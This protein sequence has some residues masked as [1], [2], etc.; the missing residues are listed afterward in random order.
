MISR[1]K[2]A[3]VRRSLDFLLETLPR[4]L[5]TGR[6]SRATPNEVFRSFDEALETCQPGYDSQIIAEVVA[7]KT[8]AYAKLLAG[9]QAVLDV[10]G[11]RPLAAVGFAGP[12]KVLRVV[13][14]GGGAGVHYFTARALTSSA[15][16]FDWRVVETDSMCTAA[17][18]LANSE[19]SFFTALDSVQAGWTEPPDLAMSVGAIMCVPEPLRALESLLKIGAPRVYIGGTGLSPD[20]ATRIMVQF[21]RLSQNGPGALPP[22]YDDAVTAYPKTF[23]PQNEFE[24]QIEACGY[25]VLAKKNDTRDAWQAGSLSINQYGYLLEKLL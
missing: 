17:Q 3:I 11:L 23:V 5:A 9:G 24:A 19:L 15:Q 16:L 4:F 7:G 6:K 12:K 1:I 8:D 18:L 20:T 14:F 2:R 25:R 21:S 22:G 13:D 10:Y